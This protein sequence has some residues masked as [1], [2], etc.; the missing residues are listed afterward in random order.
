MATLEPHA[1]IGDLREIGKWAARPSFATC[2]HTTVVL[3]AVDYEF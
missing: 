1:D 3:G 2:Q